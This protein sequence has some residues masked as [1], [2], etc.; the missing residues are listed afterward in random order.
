MVMAES[1][2]LEDID[3]GKIDRQSRYFEDKIFD[4]LVIV[5]ITENGH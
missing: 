1:T 3:N 4:R 5:S 2:V